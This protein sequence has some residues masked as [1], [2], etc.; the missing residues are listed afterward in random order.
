MFD[1]RATAE[2]GLRGAEEGEIVGTTAETDVTSLISGFEQLAERFVSGLFARAAAL[3]DVPVEFENL[4]ASLAAGGT[5]LLALLFEIVLVVALV[6][7]VFI[8][9]A[10]RFKKVAAASSAWRRFF[11]GVAAAVVALAVGFIAARL[12]AGSGA[13]LQTLR[14]WTVATVLGFVILA[15]VRS[16]LMA[17]RR[18]EFA[19]RSVHLAALVRDLSLAIGLAIIATTLLATLRLWSVGPALGDL[20]RTGLAIPTYLMFAWAVWR[21]RRTMAAAVA[22]PRPRSRWRT[23]L[24]KM[25]PAVV[26]AFVVVTFLSAQAALTLGTSLRG[27]A[28]LVTALLFLAAPHL[29]AMIGNW[30]QRG[31]ES[32]DISILAAAG[33]QTARFTVVAIMIAMLGTLWA[34]PLAAGF[35]IDLREVAKGASGVA[36]IML[37]AAFLWNVVGTATARALRAE[38]P[39]VGDD[40]MLGAPRSRLGTLVPL[41]SGIGKSSILALALLSILVS[42]G[43]NVWPLIAG[44]SVFGLAIGF[45]SQTLV[46]DLVSGLF[47]L[48]DDAFRFGEY[49]ETSGAKGTVE[50]ISVRSVSLRHQRGAL[51]TIPYGEIGKIQNFSRDWM[52]EKLTFRVAFNT[53]VEKVR[54]IFKKI[55]Q[56]ISANPE[57]AGDLLEPFKSQ[58]IAEV[59]DGTLVIRAKF[60]AKA[61]RNFMIR[62]AVLLAVHQAFR[63]NGIQAVPKPLTSNPGAA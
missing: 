61:G 58:G 13:P 35:G 15:A 45:G 52:I 44:L 54:K 2:T 4:R 56:D 30:A 57:L 47:F 20:L 62:R 36:L 11:A 37:V 14:L 12:L 7:G 21:H 18:T 59:E 29:D 27:P 55:G 9:F 33:R 3:S 17:S 16:L 41:I 43:I 50:K 10:G 26:I 46:K 23:R 8:L 25:W 24:A 19:E 38:L 5:S 31:L 51:A 48:I 60:K 28:V 39:A 6:A 22:G 42:I 53:D 40:E 1:G 32:P 49:I 34:T 63:E